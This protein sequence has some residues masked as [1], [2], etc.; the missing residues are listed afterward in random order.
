MRQKIIVKN[1]FIKENELIAETETNL[2]GLT[3]RN[4]MLVDS[5]GAA[6]IYIAEGAEDYTYIAF[7]EAVWAALKEA[8]E[9]NNPVFLVSGDNRLELTGIH[10]E[11][12]DLLV[13]IEGNGNYGD[14]FV[15]KVE[16]VFM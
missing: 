8:R 13:N 7:P 14:E 6:F 1:A 9:H 2:E 5:D 10:E 4:Q 12:S 11:L 16:Q 3:P 15:S